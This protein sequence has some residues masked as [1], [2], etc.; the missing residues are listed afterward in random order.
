MRK[1]VLALILTTTA[2]YGQ[3]F[4]KGKTSSVPKSADNSNIQVP[5]ATAVPL[6]PPPTRERPEPKSSR[7]GHEAAKPDGPSEARQAQCDEYKKTHN[8]DHIT[9]I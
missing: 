7:P 6:A 1:L 4:P 9:C 8:K 5:S 2:A 3:E